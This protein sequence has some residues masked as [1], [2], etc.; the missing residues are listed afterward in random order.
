MADILIVD[1][2]EGIC[3]AFRQFLTEEGHAPRIASN[4]E[5]AIASVEAAAPDL[6]IM[7]VRMPGQDGLQALE[8]MRAMAPDVAVVMMTAYGTS[9]TSIEAVQLGAYEYLTKPLDLDRL[10]SVIGK[11]LEAR[12]LAR[13]AAAG[14]ERADEE[15]LVTLVGTSPAMQDAYK[16]IGR[17]TT[18]DVPVLLVGERGTGKQLVARTIHA[19]SRRKERPFVA[20]D[21][22]ALPEAVLADELFGRAPAGDDRDV[23]GKVDMA[24]GGTLFLEHVGALSLPLQAKLLRLVTERT[25]E[26]A[27]GRRAVAADARVVAATDD[28]LTEDVQQGSFNPELFDALRV[29]TIRLPPLAERRDDIPELVAHFIK[30][31]NAALGKTVKCVD[32]RGL[33]L[34]ADHAWT[35]NVAE[36][37]HVIKRAS[38]LARGDV[39]TADEIRDLLE[40]RPRAVREETDAALTAAVRKALQ[41]RLAEA[42]GDKAWPPF[43]DIVG[44]AEKIL[45]REAL[46]MTSGNQLRA[47]ELLGL[48]RTTLRNKMRLYQL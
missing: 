4:A 39:I 20:V 15:T 28:D 19:N 6:V 29:I 17:V 33:E 38:I 5:D 22:M 43:H 7:D 3:T 24:S 10:R 47:A 13:A 2:D 9:Q 48:N 14:A 36:L 8:R 44:R 21:C 11:A 1:D 35:G 25:F 42:P 46:A 32:A 30:V 12:A 45:V 26:R 31:C 18:N 27:G 16:L 23:P 37:E 34:L 40:D 41:Q